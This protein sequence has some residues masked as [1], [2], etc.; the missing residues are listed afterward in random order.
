MLFS[1]KWNYDYNTKCECSDDDRCGC[2]FP[3][4]MSRGFVL[5][6]S[7]IECS[8]PSVGGKALNFTASAVLDSGQISGS[9]NFFDYIA[10]S[11]ALLVFYVA[12]F[13]SLCPVEIGRFDLAYDEFVKRNVKI[14]AVSVDSLSAH[15]AWR[16]FS[17]EEGGIGNVRFPLVSDIGKF[18]S[19]DYK[20]LQEDGTSQ[21]AVFL[22][23]PDFVIRYQSVVDPKIERSADEILHIVDKIKV[24]DQTDCQGFQCWGR[25][26]KKQMGTYSLQ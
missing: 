22:V 25:E 2:S 13:S 8:K 12:D 5:E 4:N 14:V 6:T 17:A 3:D 24:L 9:F 1:K 16:K 11:Y 23:D 26:V 15:L 18:I 21:R 20:V 10:G 7:K 19:R